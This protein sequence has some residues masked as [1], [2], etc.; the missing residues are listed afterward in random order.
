MGRVLKFL[1]YL[2]I[3]SFLGLVAFAYLGP[4]IGLDFAPPTTV[5]RQ[6]ITFGGEG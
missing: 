6:P 5:V 3:L 4:A 1:L 2:I